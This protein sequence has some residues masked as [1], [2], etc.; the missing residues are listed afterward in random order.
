MLKGI[1]DYALERTDWRLV[2]V[3]PERLQNASYLEQFDGLIVRVM[4]DWTS[5]ALLRSGKPV[6]DTYGRIDGN[7][8][9]S[10]RLDDRS[11][12]EMAFSCFEER[13]Y[14]SFAYCG[15]TGLRFSD[16]RGADFRA[17]VQ[18]NGGTCE[19]FLA[20]AKRRIDNTFFRNEKTDAP[21][22][23]SLRAWLKKLPKST[24]VFCCNDLRAIQVLEACTDIGRDVPS[25]L[26]VLGVDNDTLLCTFANPSLSSIETDPFALGRRAAEM[27][28]RQIRGKRPAG[29]A[30]GGIASEL[31]RPTCVVERLSTDAYSFKTPWLA[32]AVRYIHGH[33][34]EGVTAETVVRRS[35]Y[36]H[37]VVN[38]AFVRELGRSVKKEILH[39]RLLLACKL[40]KNTALSSGEI[41]VRCGYQSPQYFCRSFAEE[42]GVTPEIWRKP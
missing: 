10:I 1:A 38:R 37:P 24:A 36:S 30:P 22:A 11:I 41:A 27:L 16:E 32:D 40:L 33:L 26:A 15:F 12:A 8:L 31:H 28:E 17:C 25:D 7:P 3:D 42:F 29:T 13:H 9:E 23:R 14:S 21:D 18:A 4:D 5:E 20:P 19:T 35:G 2:L 34:T 39:Q 6:V